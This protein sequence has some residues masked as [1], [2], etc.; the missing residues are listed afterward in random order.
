MN[1]LF[2]VHDKAGVSDFSQKLR[3]LGFRFYATDGTADY[4]EKHGVSVNRISGITGFSDLLEGRVK[5]LH[6]VVFA[7]ILAL[8]N[9]PEHMEQLRSL[10]MS[11]IDMVV[12]DLYPFEA[13]AMDPNV[14]LEDL[15]Q[16]ID[17]GGVSLIR[18]AAKNFQHVAVV[19]ERR[20]Y[21]EVIRELEQNDGSLSA[22]FLQHL[23]ITAYRKTSYYDSVIADA[24]SRK[25]GTG[26]FP[27]MLTLNGRIKSS[28]R[29]GENPYQKAASYTKWD[30]SDCSILS[31]NVDGGK[32][33][34]YN[35]LLDANIAVEITSEFQSPVAVV[36]KHANPCGVAS[37]ESMPTA[38]SNA[39]E[40]DPISRYGSVIAVNRKV[41]EEC[42]ALFSGKF[43]EV[44]IA[45]AYTDE[46]ME[47]LRK[48]KKMRIMTYKGKPDA[49]GDVI[50][51]RRVIGGY[52]VQSAERPEISPANLKIVTERKPKDE[53]MT[54][55]LFASR[56]VRFLWSNAIVLAVGTRTVGIG[57]G[58]SSRVDAVK[59]AVAKSVGNS[60][61]SV[62][63]SDA[64][65][66]FRDGI[67]EAAKGGITAV[68]QPGGSIR[69]GEVIKAADENNMAMVFTGIRLFR[70]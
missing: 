41:T 44:M 4:L 7:S 15:I 56:I 61:G 6:P 62:M 36:V 34:S 50:D 24:L 40:A 18:A 25:F 42:A 16:N 27:E 59:L 69:D 51:I 3:K 17:I 66:P 13:T 45:P 30:S 48:R 22:Q 49:E 10:G 64:Y 70:H 23:C 5:T 12:S 21:D 43:V 14:P 46:A 57:A 2:S 39:L 9:S 52:L 32:E 20:Q 60:Q 54:G 65:F 11:P 55:M 47:M 58:Q 33:L 29:Y 68:M 8:R 19:T 67:E 26:G 37:A 1:A 35:N 63:A 31:A 38:L 28:L 53:E